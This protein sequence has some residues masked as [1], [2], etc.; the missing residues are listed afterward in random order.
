MPVYLSVASGALR[1]SPVLGTG[2]VLV[3]QAR[4]FLLPPLAETLHRNLRQWNDLK[5]SPGPMTPDRVF[6]GNGGELTFAF[7]ENA[8]P[9][10]LMSNVGIS[11]DLAGW[12]VLLDK[13]IDTSAV[14]AR[15]RTVWST[16]EVAGALPFV[17]PAFLPASLVTYAP[18]NCARVARAL[19]SVVA[20][21]NPQS[22]SEN[23]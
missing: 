17:T 22:P 15:A 21:G 10:P 8:Q 5:L 13:W 3:T 9:G 14:V 18:D 16:T 23:L 12:L 7:A 20:G 11:L 2:L 4:S 19:A 1:R 6:V